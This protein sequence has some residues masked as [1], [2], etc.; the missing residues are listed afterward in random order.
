MGNE[1][2]AG[3]GR[4]ASPRPGDPWLRNLD[5]AFRA[6]LPSVLSLLGSTWGPTARPAAGGAALPHCSLDV[7]VLLARTQAIGQADT[8]KLTVGAAVWESGHGCGSTE[9]AA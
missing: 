3:R 8:Q 7:H 2:E 9:Q 4:W 5:R 6:R 1:G